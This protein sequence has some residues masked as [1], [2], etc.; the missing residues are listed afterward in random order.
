M[1]TVAKEMGIQTSSASPTR[2]TLIRKGFVYTP[3]HGFID[4]TVPLFDEFLNR[5]ED[6]FDQNVGC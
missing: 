5:T 3:R 2:A 4:F 1:N 6:E